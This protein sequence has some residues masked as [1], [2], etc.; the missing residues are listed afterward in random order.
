[1][2][3]YTFAEGNLRKFKIYGCRDLDGSGSWDSWTLL[4]DCESIKPSG[5]PLGQNSNDDI[6][7]A[8]NGEDFFNSPSN[9]AVRY[10]RIL[11]NQTWEGGDNFQI[12][13]FKIFGDNR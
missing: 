4:M 5:L 1:M 3:P 13:E 7:V 2:D 10:I 11:V 6:N 12:T 8:A 9:P